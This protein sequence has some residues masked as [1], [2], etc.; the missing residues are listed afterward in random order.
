MYPDAQFH[1]WWEKGLGC[2]PIL[3]GHVIPIL[4]ALQAHPESPRLWDTHISK[5]LI[6]ELGFKATIHVPCLYYKH[7]NN[8]E[9]VKS[10]IV[11]EQ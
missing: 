6:N 3:E 7:N 4:K 2:K 11:L 1:Q 9:T 8:D 10:A 5:M